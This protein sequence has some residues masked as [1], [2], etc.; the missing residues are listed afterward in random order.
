[1]GVFKNITMFYYYV[2]CK[3]CTTVLQTDVQLS[4][5][6]AELDKL[7]KHLKLTC[8]T[9]KLSESYDSSRFFLLENRLN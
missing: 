8:P 7:T 1:M 3:R 6:G 4:S 9:C 2:K 5:K